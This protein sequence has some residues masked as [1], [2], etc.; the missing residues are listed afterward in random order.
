MRPDKRGLAGES[1]SGAPTVCPP[2]KFAG[3]PAISALLMITALDRPGRVLQAW[4]PHG[5][6]LQNEIKK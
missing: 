5:E 6:W 4:N 2:C 3:L 1:A